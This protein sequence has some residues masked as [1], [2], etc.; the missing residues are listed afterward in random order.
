MPWFTY[1]AIEALKTWNLSQKTVLEYG[2]GYSTLFWAN[3]VKSV[4]SIEHNPDWYHK[5]SNMIPENVDIRLRALETYPEIDGQF[6]IIVIDGYA[7]ARM[8]YRCANASLQY[9][10]PNGM[11]ILDNSDWLPATC[12]FLRQA[13]LIQ[14]DFSGFVPGNSHTQTTSIFL[15]RKFDFDHDQR[16]TPVGGTGYNWEPVLEKELLS[17]SES[18]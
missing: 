3:R 5:V 16:V 1:P 15:T 7:Q 13:G 14:M 12:L 17:Q 18:T 4:V 6:D 8:R 10:K 9:L 2:S 11:V